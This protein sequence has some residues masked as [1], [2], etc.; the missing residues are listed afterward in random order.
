MSLGPLLW[1][2]ENSRTDVSIELDL[3]QMKALAEEMGFEIQVGLLCFHSA[4]P[5][6]IRKDLFIATIDFIMQ[7]EKAI[8][9]TYTN[10]VQSMLEYTYHSAMWTAVKK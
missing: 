3:E 9:A 1:H 6:P 5:N 10:N 8:N 7:D 4:H 2:W